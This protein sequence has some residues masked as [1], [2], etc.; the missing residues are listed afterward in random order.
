MYT[1]DFL[2]NFK[3]KNAFVWLCQ[4]LIVARG[5]FQLWRMNS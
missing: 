1:I 3:K 2:V 5:I 4:V